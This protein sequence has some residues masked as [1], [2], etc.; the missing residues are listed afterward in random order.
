MYLPKWNRKGSR[1]KWANEK[2]LL[3]VISGRN[4]SIKMKDIIKPEEVTQERSKKELIRDL[5]RLVKEKPL[6]FEKNS[7]PPL[8]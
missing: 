5:Q 3:D 2:Y 6:G 4:F 8:K 1:Q 7:E